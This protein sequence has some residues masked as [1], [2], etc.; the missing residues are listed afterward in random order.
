MNPFHSKHDAAAVPAATPLASGIAA[1]RST[2][3][4]TNFGLL[5]LLIAI[6]ILFGS[7]AGPQLFNAGS[8]RAMAFQLPELG[9][10]SLAMLI[11]LLSG[12]LDLSIIATANLSALAMAWVCTRITPGSGMLASVPWLLAALMAGLA[13]AALVG[14]L[15]GW[16]IARLRVSPILATLGSMTLV[17]GVAVGMTHGGVISGF[18]ESVRFLG[19]GLVLGVPAALLLFVVVAIPVSVMLTRSPLGVRIA[20]IGSNENATRY[21]GVDTK[22]VLRRVYLLSSLLSAL[23]GLVMMARFDSANAAYGESY[24]LVTILA[25][26]LGGVSPTG[27]FGRVSGLVLA[28]VIL[29]LIST[30]ASMI[31][32]SQFVTLSIWGATLIGVAGVGALRVWWGR[33]RQRG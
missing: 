25:A 9:L 1:I 7:I 17:K 29:Q 24:L 2:V 21:S 15:N 28:L 23:A 14:T 5:G 20:M 8:M 30:A 22:G 33:Q 4:P 10:L 31:D 11:P 26:V 19:H 18:P 27:G 16:L 13:V 12:G 6:S 32:L 3:G